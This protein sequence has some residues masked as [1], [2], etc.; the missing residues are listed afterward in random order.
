MDIIQAV[1]AISLLLRP[2]AQLVE[3]RSPKPKVG[4]SIPSWPVFDITTTC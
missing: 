4:G 2:I 1:R 3:R